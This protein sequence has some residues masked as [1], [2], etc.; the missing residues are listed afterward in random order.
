MN[1]V[2]TNLQGPVVVTGGAGF[3]GTNLCNRLALAGHDVIIYDNLSRNG[4]KDNLEW[5]SIQHG[6]KIKPVIADVRNASDLNRCI[7][8][9][10]VVFHLAAQVAVTTSINDPREDFDVNLG[11][12]I[13]VLESVRKSKKCKFLLYTSTNKVYGQLCDLALQKDNKR[14]IPIDEQA[15]KGINERRNLDFHSPYGCSKGG[16]EQYVLD[17][18]RIYNLP[19]VVFRMSCMYGP[20]QFGNE[21]Q[22]W[23]AHFVINH[24]EKKGITLFGD[25]FQVRDV[26]YVDDLI[27]A[28]ALAIKNIE[29]IKGNA[30]NIGGGPQNAV[31]LLE[32]IDFISELDGAEANKI[33]APWRSGDQK[34]YISDFSDFSVK[35]GWEPKVSWRNGVKR[36]YRWLSEN[37]ISKV[38]MEKE[39]VG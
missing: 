39:N 21:D 3:I 12:T 25:G 31:S 33:Y 38:S 10:S 23:V 9:A 18:A 14:Y 36:L 20:H 1:G 37:R 16:S 22:G 27:H 6:N 35:T 30:F 11:G 26:L 15:M 2:F 19:A 28:F 29:N 32:T 24:L 17:Y 34:F 13:N 7:Q 5:L 8:C 4:S